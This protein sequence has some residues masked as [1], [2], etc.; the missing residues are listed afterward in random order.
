MKQTAISLAVL[1]ALSGCAS[2][3]VMEAANKAHKD[4]TDQIDQAN[5]STDRLTNAPILLPESSVPYLPRKSAPRGS[6]KAELP[7]A[8]RS[9]KLVHFAAQGQLTAQQ[10]ARLL[11]EEFKM[12]VKAEL[13]LA[14]PSEKT[15]SEAVATD[16]NA[17]EKNANEKLTPEKQFAQAPRLD[18]SSIPPMPLLELVNTATRLLGTDW[19]WQDGTLLIQRSFT[20]TYDVNLSQ[21]TTNEA[22][23]KLGKT[24]NSQT[25]GATGNTGAAGSFNSE[26]LTNTE[27]KSVPWDDLVNSLTQ[28]AGPK[29]VVAG[30]YFNKVT[31]T[32]DKACHR[33]VK[34]F[35]DNGNHSATQQVLLRV[36]EITVETTLGGDS[37]V[38][39]NL[40][41]RTVLDNRKF[42]YTLSTPTSLVGSGAG[43]VAAIFQPANPAAPGGAEGSSFIAKAIST[44]S[45]TIDVKPY[46]TLVGNNETATLGNLAQ[47]SYVQSFSITPSTVV[48][49]QPIITANSA[50]VSFGQF[51][52]VRPTILPDGSIKVSFT[53]DDSTGK[54]NKGDSSKGVTDEVLM[55]AING[56]T[57]IITRPGSTMVVASIKRIT[58]RSSA[59]GL[60]VDQQMGSESG[61]KSATE[62]IILVTPYLANAGAL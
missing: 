39:W 41:Y 31:V 7:A 45:K 60:L 58:H 20:R 57:R 29:N 6:F 3:P 51:I 38:D 19:D 16:K 42:N 34:Q 53:L 46:S 59:Q 56:S 40:V 30:R 2:T 13:E 5:A 22:K 55:N 18:I 17:A 26:V 36:Q 35:I 24:G 54:V 61:T 32:C 27:Y 12:S 25:G 8:M 44:A 1:I 52:Q 50:Y 37:G 47:Q 11:A 43:A 28:I 15:A 33:I 49:S 62:T 21:E 4:V 23:A 14:S 10:F 48:G 9:N